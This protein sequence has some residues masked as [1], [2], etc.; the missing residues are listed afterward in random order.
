M[1]LMMTVLLCACKSTAR[2]VQY[3]IN[4]QNNQNV[5]DGLYYDYKD[6]VDYY[7][8]CAGDKL[9]VNTPGQTG[10]G[11]TYSGIPA[12][13]NISDGEFAFI[14]ADVTYVSGGIAGYINAPSLTEIDSQKTVTLDEVVQAGSLATYNP[15][16]N[17]YGLKIY[18]DN[19]DTYLLA[20]AGYNNF[21]LYL[22][23]TYVD[24]YTNTYDAEAMMGIRQKADPDA[25]LERFGNLKCYIF[26]CDGRY[27]IYT[28]NIVFNEKGIWREF[29]NADF[30]NEPKDFTLRDGEVLCLEGTELMRVNGGE[31]NY[32]NAP[33]YIGSDGMT[34]VDHETL[35]DAISMDHWE[36]A[37]ATHQFETRQYGVGDAVIFLMDGEYHV[38]REDK[39]LGVYNTVD[40][41]NE[42]LGNQ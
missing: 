8:F 6:N 9:L 4:N 36:E 33:M 22:N 15:D 29:L 23:G 11:V 18:R 25:E 31:G 28:R 21:R 34:G 2:R 38:Y 14:T 40:E 7:V 32:D 12:S 24:H 39:L 42:A 16:E 17:F 30:G 3:Q 37:P 41:V 1:S 19:N 27:F 13:L 10:W 5:V 20:Y 35:I 26:C